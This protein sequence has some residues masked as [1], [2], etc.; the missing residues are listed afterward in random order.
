MV[1]GVRVKNPH[2]M[3]IEQVS[4]QGVAEILG[5][6]HRVTGLYFLKQKIPQKLGLN[7][8]RLGQDHW[9]LTA[10]TAKRPK[11]QFKGIKNTW[12]E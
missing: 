11:I 1:H 8:R 2:G 4:S 5:Y 7:M 3:F 12:F 10:N 9:L 6:R